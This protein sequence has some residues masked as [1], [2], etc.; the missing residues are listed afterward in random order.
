MDSEKERSGQSND[1]STLRGARRRFLAECGR[2]AIATPPAVALLLSASERKY[3]VAQSGG[4][5]GNNGWGNGSDP[6]NPG[7]PNGGTAP[8]KTANGTAGPGIN[9]NPTTSNGR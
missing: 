8:S 7:S 2:F 6:S 9:T 5:K 4:V 1:E 3:A